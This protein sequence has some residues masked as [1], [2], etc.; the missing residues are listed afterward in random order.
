MK[1]NRLRKK[2][3]GRKL[4]TTNRRRIDSTHYDNIFSHHINFK[5]RVIYLNDDINEYS[6]ELILKAFDELERG[7]GCEK[8]IRIDVSSYG[9]SVYDMMGMVDRIK[10]SPC[11]VITRGFGKIMSAASFILAA[12]DE[13]ILGPHSWIM[14]HELSDWLGRQK[15]TDLK[16]DLRQDERLQDQ[17][18][19]MYAK[20]AQGKTKKAS[21]KKLCEKDCYITAEQALKIGLI[22]RITR[23]LG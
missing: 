2:T 20:F 6:L 7:E 17:M 18:Y 23:R 13:R 15:L 10:S 5:E 21:F 3:Q 12:G 16:H 8:P 22:D 14:I 4:N 19:E 11:H 1:E 9:G